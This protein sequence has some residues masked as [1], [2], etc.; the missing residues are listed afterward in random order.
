MA[1]KTPLLAEQKQA[2]A[3]EPPEAPP[4]K[5]AGK[6]KKKKKEP[7]FGAY[8]KTLRAALRRC[9]LLYSGLLLATYFAASLFCHGFLWP[10]FLFSCN[11]LFSSDYQLLNGSGHPVW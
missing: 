6:A 4:P 5:P 2:P 3:P 8:D 1:S 10:A 11:T 9:A 7:F